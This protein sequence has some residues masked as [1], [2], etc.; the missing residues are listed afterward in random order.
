MTTDAPNLNLHK[1]CCVSVGTTKHGDLDSD[2]RIVIVSSDLSQKVSNPS[3][4]TITIQQPENL[5]EK[6]C[7]SKGTAFS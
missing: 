1:K 2:C 5:Y 3:E 7:V 4:L 6:C